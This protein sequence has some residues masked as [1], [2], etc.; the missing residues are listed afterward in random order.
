[1][2]KSKTKTRGAILLFIGYL[3]V[4]IDARKAD[5][6]GNQNVDQNV[7]LERNFIDNREHSSLMRNGTQELFHRMEHAV[8]NKSEMMIEKAK[9]GFHRVSEEFQEIKKNQKQNPFLNTNQFHDDD[10]FLEKVPRNA[11][12]S[13][14]KHPHNET[15]QLNPQMHSHIRKLLAIVP[16]I[17]NT[18]V[19]KMSMIEAQDE[20]DVNSENH[21]HSKHL[22]SGVIFVIISSI[23]T[24]LFREY[25][26]K[27]SLEIGGAKKYYSVT[28]LLS[29]FLSILMSIFVNVVSMKSHSIQ[30]FSVLNVKFLLCIIFSSLFYLG[31]PFYTRGF[32]A[33]SLT[34]SMHVVSNSLIPVIT[35]AFLSI[36]HYGTEIITK[37]ICISVLCQIYGLFLM[38]YQNQNEFTQLHSTSILDQTHT[39]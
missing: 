5:H 9:A 35:A 27:L 4:W 29:T 23:L 13:T 33:S 15:E 24:Q 21:C 3:L 11:D 38:T 32:I 1:M 26:R 16:E 22:E 6:N 36:F 2:H 10:E 17:S 19:S 28:L 12:D 25:N 20:I 8:R 34:H 30:G 37:W 7:D 18:N 31:F 14:R 39:C